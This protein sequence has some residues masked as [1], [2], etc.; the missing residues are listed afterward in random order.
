MTKVKVEYTI[1][2]FTGMSWIDWDK[3]F[4][5]VIE[6]NKDGLS[7]IDVM[8]E[9]IVELAKSFVGTLERLKEIKTYSIDISN[10][11]ISN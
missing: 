6:V 7:K 5:R 9:A 3:T 8:N 4:E 2:M 1:R 10:E 11:K